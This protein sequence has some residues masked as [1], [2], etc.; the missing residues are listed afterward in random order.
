MQTTW[1]AAGA[2][3]RRLTAVH[4]ALATLV[5]RDAGEAAAKQGN[6]G[7]RG[8]CVDYGVALKSEKHG[9]TSV[10]LVYRVYIVKKG[11]LKKLESRYGFN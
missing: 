6:N 2:G 11:L 3:H 7:F 9:E 1:L 4:E 8:G 5:N 10:T